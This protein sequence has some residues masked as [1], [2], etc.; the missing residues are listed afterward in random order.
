MKT[1]NT[2]NENLNSLFN[3]PK[4]SPENVADYLAHTLEYVWKLGKG[5]NEVD[6]KDMA[7]ALKSDIFTNN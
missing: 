1:L 2:K 5:N 6:F 3:E 4:I 7:Q